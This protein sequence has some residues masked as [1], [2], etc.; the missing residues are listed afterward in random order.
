MS[1][2]QQTGMAQSYKISEGAPKIERKSN[3]TYRLMYQQES[4]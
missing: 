2:R 4:I 3:D 1:H